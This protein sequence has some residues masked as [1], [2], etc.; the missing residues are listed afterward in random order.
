M[1]VDYGRALKDNKFDIRLALRQWHNREVNNLVLSGY[2]SKVK[3][4]ID[5]YINNGEYLINVEIF[6]NLIILQRV[7][8][9]DGFKTI[10]QD[11]V[12]F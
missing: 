1:M 2:Y 10:S 8:P 5:R 9:D 3:Y 12:E 4:L 11:K 6:S 7:S